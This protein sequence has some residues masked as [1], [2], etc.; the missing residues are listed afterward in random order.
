MGKIKIIFSVLFWI[1]PAFYYSSNSVYD[2][3]ISQSNQYLGVVEKGGNNR[4]FSDPIFEYKLKSVGWQPGQAWC[5]Y[6]VKM[7]LKEC[8]VPNTITGW[9][10]TSY[11][12]KDVIYTD[13]IF[14]EGFSSK[15][16]LVM[17]LSYTKFKADKSRYKGIG[18]TGL[19]VSLKPTSV[20]TLE[21]NTND[22]GARDSRTG[23]GFYKKKRLLNKNTHITRWAKY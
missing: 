16:I 9:S 6:T 8:N 3:I 1:I 19:V 10:P 15:D 12:K 2:C 5:A 4:G 21:G 17:S 13:G 7:L 23:D 20:V 11:N 18:H 14:L 22:L